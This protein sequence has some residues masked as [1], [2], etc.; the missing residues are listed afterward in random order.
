[1]IEVVLKKMRYVQKSVHVEQ[2]GRK[3]HQ[4]SGIFMIPIITVTM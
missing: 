1:M 2:A 4:V 3:H